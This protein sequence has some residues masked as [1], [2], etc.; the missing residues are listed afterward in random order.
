MLKIENVEVFN[1]EGAIRGCR[2]PKASWKLSDS[3]WKD[4]TTEVTDS[5][6]G[7]QLGE[8][9]TDREFVVGE[10]DLDLMRRLFKGGSE[11]RKYLRQIFVSL[12]MTCSQVLWMQFDTYKIG[13][14][15][16]SCSK[17]HRIHVKAFE[18]DDFSHEGISAVGGFAEDQFHRTLETLEKLRNLFNETKEKKYWRAMIELLPSGYNLKATITMNYENVANIIHQ[19]R[20]HK[21]DEWNQFIDFLE[22]LPYVKE[23]MF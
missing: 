5:A 7:N 6:T 9:H 10:K 14:T 21:M 20:G 4:K 17:M 22:T 23:I 1:F 3:Y 18:P 19:R 11:H 12:D 13:T 15:K 2:N 8:F 16:N